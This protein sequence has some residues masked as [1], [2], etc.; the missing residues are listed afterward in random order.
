MG[1]DICLLQRQQREGSPLQAHL[2]SS[3]TSATATPEAAAEEL[4]RA[5]LIPGLDMRHI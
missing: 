2:G 5:K 4:L 3:L 1:F